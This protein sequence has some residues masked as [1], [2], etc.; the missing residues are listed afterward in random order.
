MDKY[1]NYEAEDFLS[2]E[3]FISWVLDPR[4]VHLPFW[5]KW[6]SEHPH[7]AQ[8]IN[9]AKKVL[10]SLSIKPVDDE[11]TDQEMLIISEY[12]EQKALTSSFESR[13]SRV[14]L[15]SRTWFRVAAV[16][17]LFLTAGLLIFTLRS[18]RNN[19]AGAGIP[20]P[21]LNKRAE[22][23]KKDD[24]VKFYNQT[25][26]AKLVR[27]SDGSL[28]ILHPQSELSYPNLFTGAN[29]AVKLKG[30]AFFEVH[31]NSKHPF[32]VYSNNM[33]TKVLG[34]SFK[35]K[36]FSKDH[37]F[38]VI[39]N[40]GKVLIYEDSNSKKGQSVTLISNQQAIF[41]RRQLKF[42]KDTVSAPQMLSENEADRIFTFNNTP[43]PVII[44]KLEDAYQVTIKYDES[45]FAHTTVTASLSKLPLDEKIKVIC[46]AVDAECDFSKGNIS[47]K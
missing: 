32:L 27:L 6:I 1:E 19:M 18:D 40:T 23:F 2:D 16:L 34:T 46:K 31:K 3:S 4:S 5:N 41:N 35:I 11:L 8:N 10:L 17:L 15:F 7:R 21:G 26:V 33:I 39:V 14:P 30:E 20:M 37:E 47:I 22:T 43:L 44:S 45:K 28:V 12:I 38:K 42:T 29:R 36:A 24:S 9:K 13:T 25:K